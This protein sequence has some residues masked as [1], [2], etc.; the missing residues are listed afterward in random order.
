MSEDLGITV[1]KDENISEWYQQVV[2]KSGLADYT[3]VSGCIV[4]RP[5]SY[6]IWENVKNEV[7]K[8]FKEI[9]IENIYFP[10]FIPENLLEKEAEHFDGFVPEVAWVTRTGSSELDEKL[11]VRPTSET[12]M[13][14]SFSKWIR[15]WRDLPFKRNQW[16]NVV[17]WEFKH[18]T[19][20]LRSR[21][22]LWN[23]GHNVYETEEEA[24]EDRDNVLDIYME[25][26][27]DY[28][29]L[30]GVPGRKSEREK[31]DGA[32]DTYS[33]EHILPDGKAIQGPDY[34]YDGTNFAEAFD[35]TYTDREGN[36][37][38]PVQSTYAITT[39]E[40][41]VMILMHAD[42]DGL[43][44]PPR[45]APTKTVVIPIYSDD[46]DKNDVLEYARDVKSELKDCRIDDRDHRSP[47]FKFNEWELKGVPLRIE[48]GPNEFEE[49][50]VTIVRR[51]NGESTTVSRDEVAGT[52]DE[53]MDKIHNNLYS[54]AE[55]L[56]NESI[57]ETRDYNELK[58]IVEDKG[59]FIKAPFCGE[60]ECG[61]L[62]KEETKAKV[63]NYPFKYDKPE[64]EKCIKCDKEAEH[65]AHF[66]KS[67]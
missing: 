62:I 7:D 50:T 5:L 48:I 61:E 18:A 12:I 63:T 64:N 32:V 44:V 24:L 38:Y 53:L 47:G 28:L 4:Y 10:L 19:P 45:V 58:E 9:G 54:K 23:E 13:Y 25:V 22:F 51:D 11:A 37:K 20:F 43:I 52:V 41:G 67:Y 30:P 1:S 59:G 36:Q 2:I 16:N 26:L 8:R 66:A 33:I 27:E 3:D 57:T 49:G 40:L 31:F 6:N 29:A 21:E 65:W 15:S 34:H 46:E 35:I 17:R 55:R 56:L 14:S 60:P 42:D 39:R